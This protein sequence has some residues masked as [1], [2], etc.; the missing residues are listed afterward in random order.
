MKGEVAQELTCRGMIGV[1]VAIEEEETLHGA[2]G[3]FMGRRWQRRPSGCLD[4]NPNLPS[5][6][7]KVSRRVDE[8]HV[9]DHTDLATEEVEQNRYPLLIPNAF[10]QA[11]SVAKGA[12]EHPY[13]IT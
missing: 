1:E 2:G 7:L 9:Q 6:R 13:L 8:V 4:T 3:I 11:E 12:S 10:E 5:A